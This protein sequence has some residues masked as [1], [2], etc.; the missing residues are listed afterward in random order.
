M[1][2]A[3]EMKTILVRPRLDD[4]FENKIFAREEKMYPAFYGKEWAIA[5]R[6]IL[7][8]KGYCFETCDMV[9]IATFLST[10]KII[11]MGF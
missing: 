5:L 6:N 3:F 11:F 8:R 1:G 4:Q 2:E 9:T 10:E 7:E